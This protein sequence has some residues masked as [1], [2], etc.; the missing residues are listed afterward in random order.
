MKVDMSLQGPNSL[1]ILQACADDKTKK[2]LARLK[3]LEFIFV[4]LEGI[5][6][7]VSRTGYTGEDIGYELYLHPDDAPKL[8]RLL[9]EK[10]ESFG[11]KP[12]GLGARDSTR[13]EA[14]FPLYGNELS[15]EQ[16]IDPVEAGYGSFVR[17][18]KPFFIGRKPL[19][20]RHL[21]P[22][23]AVIRFNMLLKG[24]RAIRPNYPVYN[25]NN[26][27]IGIVTSCTLIE[28]IQ[29]GMALIDCKYAKEE[30]HINVSLVS[31]ERTKENG[32]KQKGRDY[33]E[34][35]IIT[36]FMMEIDEGDTPKKI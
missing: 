29:V 8:W 22:K 6:V 26:E 20:E 23:R 35:E 33:E 15:G 28:G 11:I 17:F 36:R 32:D 27:P 9:L 1:K 2:E 4:R 34:A 19:F 31:P 25:L 14:G 10:G 18:H 21:N 7:M 16:D 30:E 24:I 3:K 13:T 12:C 5:H